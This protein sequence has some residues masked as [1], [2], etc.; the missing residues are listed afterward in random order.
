MHTMFEASRVVVVGAGI[1][2]LTAA[3]ELARRGVDV[4]VIERAAHVG[5]KMRQ[6]PI[7]GRAIDSG[8]TVLTLRNVFDEVF[9]A[10]GEKLNEHL[11]LDRMDLLAR[12]AWTDGSVL[13]LYSDI[14]RS[15]DAIG[16]FAGSREAYGYRRFCQYAR[17][18]HEMVEG[19][20]LMG[21]KPNM[22]SVVKAFS[23]IG[24]GA[25]MKM[26]G[27][28]TLWASLGDF[29]QDPRLLQLFGRYA[30]YC[31]SSPFAAPAT[32]NVIAHVEREGV[33][34]VRGGMAQLAIALSKLAIKMGATIKT[35][36]HVS[37]VLVHQ[38][39]ASGIKLATGEVIHAGAVVLNADSGALP[40]GLFGK[41]VKRA[42][43]TPGPRSLSAITWSCLAT[44]K[45]LPLVRHNVCFSNNYPLE[46]KE[47]FDKRTPP[48]SPTV[49]ICAQDRNDSGF[50]P[51]TS[52]HRNENGAQADSSSERLL[53]LINAPAKG[54]EHTFSTS[55]IRQ[56]EAAMK[57]VLMRCGLSITP[58]AEPVVT[59][60]TDFA[61]MFPATGGAL[62][63]AVSHGMTSPFSRPA[64]RSEMPGLYLTGGSVHPG[65]GVPMV[66]QSGRLAAQ[67]LF[68]D[69]VSIS[70][71]RVGVM[72]GGMSMR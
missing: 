55:E 23:T 53:L 70:R 51:E 13:D 63:G 29:F 66:A 50:A 69:L 45:G 12:H 32:L 1:G 26:D 71:S 41:S 24:V 38:G 11:T 61:R 47:L 60:P 59:T 42:V 54:D 14:D 33:W 6:V 7:Q 4:T 49:Y 28:R 25:L 9:Q 16:K 8:P 57:E 27:V 56:C 65:A 20:F 52:L 62:Y 39:R 48:S 36:T 10:A 35:N 68:Q 43:K 5:G 34:T 18:I 15:A 44:T 21:E 2:G 67:A 58:T 30:T 64:A 22:L 31:G 37:E 17:T 19:P 40:A 46:F 72:A 3:V